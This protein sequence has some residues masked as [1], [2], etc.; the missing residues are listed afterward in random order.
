MFPKYCSRKNAANPSNAK[1]NLKYD[2]RFKFLFNSAFNEKKI[3]YTKC[4]NNY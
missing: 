4:Y 3:K 2:Y 1:M